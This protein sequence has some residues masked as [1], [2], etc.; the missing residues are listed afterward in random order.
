MNDKKY[1]RYE[2]VG[3]DNY[4][5]SEEYNIATTCLGYE[6]HIY[7]DNSLEKL[8]EIKNKIETKIANKDY[9]LELEDIEQEDGDCYTWSY[10]ITYDSDDNYISLNDILKDESYGLSF[11]DYLLFVDEQ[12]NRVKK[13]VKD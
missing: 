4:W 11:N 8:I 13:E 6:Y 9:V 12:L 5:E 7:T 1:T 2:D 3:T 10:S